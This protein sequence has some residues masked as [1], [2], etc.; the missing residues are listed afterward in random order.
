[1]SKAAPA[2][3]PADG[4]APPKKK[5]KLLLIIIIAVVVLALAGGGAAF[6][7]MKKK[8][9]EAEAEG[10]TSDHKEKP[11]K[12]AKKHKAEPGKPPVY[13]PLEPFTVKL[14]GDGERYVQTTLQLRV[15]DPKAADQIKAF[16]PTIRSNVNKLLMRTKP[17]TLDSAEGMDALSNDIKDEVN[18]VVG[19]PGG[20]DKKGKPYPAEGPVES[21]EFTH[22]IVQ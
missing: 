12:V 2:A 5:S 19:T 7:I 11:T 8:A 22:F 10:D 20:I 3:A 9:A 17:S 14:F 4:E 6:F 21:V 18:G 13:V 15:D 1:M 16:T